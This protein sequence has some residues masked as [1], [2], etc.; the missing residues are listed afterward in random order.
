MSIYSLFYSLL[1]APQ[2][3][4]EQKATLVYNAMHSPYIMHIAE[5]SILSFRPRSA[6]LR[7]NSDLYV[8][9]RQLVAI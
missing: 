6:L 8:G 1:K 4:I 5:F 9:R 2:Y 7:K 3:H